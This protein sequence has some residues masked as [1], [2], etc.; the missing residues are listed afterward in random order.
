MGEIEV[1]ALPVGL[2]DHYLG[3]ATNRELL[4]I[5]LLDRVDAQHD[6]HLMDHMPN[7]AYAE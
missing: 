1:G 4:A 6:T 2:A 7:T 3:I 5:T